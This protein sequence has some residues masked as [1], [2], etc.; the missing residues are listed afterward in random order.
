VCEQTSEVGLFAHDLP[1]RVALQAG[2]EGRP[3][4]GGAALDVALAPLAVAYGPAA[5]GGVGDLDAFDRDGAL[6]IEVADSWQWEMPSPCQPAPDDE[7][8]RGLL[9][10]D[11][12][13]HSWGVKP[14][15]VG[16]IVWARVAP[17]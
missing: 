13:S 15:Q 7:S 6:Y 9:L 4:G 17:C 11:A 3:G 16:K 12:L 2:E 8:G 14:R 1:Q 5:V 10:V